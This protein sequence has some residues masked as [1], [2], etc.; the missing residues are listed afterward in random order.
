M[1]ATA[2][3]PGP[4]TPRTPD[5]EAAGSAAAPGTPRPAASPGTPGR[6]PAAPAP[7]P[8]AGSDRH[9]HQ[10]AAALGALMAVF[11]VVVLVDA[12]SLG[13]GVGAAL[14][15]PGG[16]PTVVGVLLVAVGAALAVR[17]LLA[18]R[19]APAAAPA[20][21]LKGRFLRLAALVGALVVFA[22]V[23]PYAGFTLSSAL[24]FTA[25]AL[26]LG[27][28]HPWRTAAYGWTLAGVLFLLFDVLIGLSLPGGPW[29]F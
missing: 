6:P 22:V 7:A 28:P 16:F 15:G 9:G 26:L 3:T 24:L 12:A 8:E 27:A 10:A 4:R 20:A 23:L 2:D 1:S 25:A 13:D 29:G 19:T 18:L 11:G 21:E 17:A 5:A 14:V